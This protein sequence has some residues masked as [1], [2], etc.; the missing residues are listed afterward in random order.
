MLSNRLAQTIPEQVPPALVS[1]G[2]PASSVANFI[3][4]ITANSA[5]AW[6][7]VEGLTPTIQAIGIKAYQ[8]ASSDAFKTVYLSTLAF[9]G[10]GI[11]LCFFTPNVDHL[12][13]SDVAI[14]LHER[15][16]DNVVGTRTA[17]GEEKV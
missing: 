4:A 16:G 3:A 5:A 2:L 6:Q 12:L 17:E 9:S 15:N 10:V 11:I 8:Q 7:A 1:A 14:T 13:T